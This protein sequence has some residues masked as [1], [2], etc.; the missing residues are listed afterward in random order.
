MKEDDLFFMLIKGEEFIVSLYLFFTDVSTTQIIE[1][2]KS[3]VIG[4]YEFLRKKNY[5]VNS[6]RSCCM[7][8][9][10]S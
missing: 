10:S 9:D 1:F 8:F 3:Q 7:L 2:L 4:V 6:Y 5:L